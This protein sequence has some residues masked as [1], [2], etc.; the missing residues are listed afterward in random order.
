LIKTRIEKTIKQHHYIIIY[1][2]PKEGKY[3]KL[4]YH[5]NRTIKK[6]EEQY[7]RAINIVSKYHKA[8][9]KLIDCPILSISKWNEYKG[10]KKPE[11]YT[12]EDF[13]VTKQI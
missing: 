4:K 1:L 13:L 9:I 6:I 8:E 5:N 7:K 11:A 12:V 3:I 10:H 2:T